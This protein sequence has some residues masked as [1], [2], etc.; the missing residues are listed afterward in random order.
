[1]T[2]YWIK[3]GP[4][5][6]GQCPYNKRKVT[7][8]GESHAKMEGETGVTRSEAK[9]CLLEETRKDSATGFSEEARPCQHTLIVDFKSPDRTMRQ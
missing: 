8:E 4:K 2:P 9:E 3:A 6:N 5:S 1:M 7:D